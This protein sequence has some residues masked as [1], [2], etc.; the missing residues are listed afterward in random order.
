MC[1]EKIPHY[2]LSWWLILALF[3][4]R[5]LGEYC[6]NILSLDQVIQVNQCSLKIC[7]VDPFKAYIQIMR[8]NYNF[9]KLSNRTT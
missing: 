2:N 6:K 5:S 7:I 1:Q 4:I 3:T 8:Y 9:Q